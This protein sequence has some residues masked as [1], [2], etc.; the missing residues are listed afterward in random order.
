VRNKRLIILFSILLSVTVIVIFGSIIFSVSIV[1]TSGHN[2]DVYNEGRDLSEQIIEAAN[3][4][5]RSIFLLNDE[6]II[7]EIEEAV[8]QI[9]VTYIQRL[10]PNRV[11]IRFVKMYNYFRVTRGDNTYSLRSNG[12]ITDIND[13]T[14]RN[15]IDLI[16]HT[17]NAAFNVGDYMFNRTTSEFL[18]EVAASLEKLGVGE[19][20]ASNLIEFVNIVYS[21]NNV[22]I[23]MRGGGIIRILYARENFL[24]K[25]QLGLSVFV[26]GSHARG[27]VVT[28]TDVHAFVSS[29]GDY[30]VLRNRL[31]QI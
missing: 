17:S 4:N 2:I 11:L 25:L 8:P 23:G 31:T 15:F 19:S 26:A 9:Q 28:S 5:G 6:Q 29:P 7:A 21:H 24:E 18:M 10:F 13:V 1:T 30:M 16:A 14:D 12:R 22:Y 27:Y 3:L 20:A